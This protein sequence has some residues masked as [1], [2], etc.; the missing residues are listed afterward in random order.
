MANFV[1]F[2]TMAVNLWLK[3]NEYLLSMYSET[4]YYV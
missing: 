1:E 2:V 4:K 3:H